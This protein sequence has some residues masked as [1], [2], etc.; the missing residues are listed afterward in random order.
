MAALVERSSSQLHRVNGVLFTYLFR[1]KV[2]QRKA[3]GR[4]KC[5]HWVDIAYF[6]GLVSW[7]CVSCSSVCSQRAAIVQGESTV[8][9]SHLICQLVWESLQSS[10]F[11]SPALAKPYQ[12]GAAY[13]I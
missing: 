3:D 12:A 4:T 7:Y 1:V 13:V 8:F 5:R 6:S 9:T 11:L 2:A 10:L